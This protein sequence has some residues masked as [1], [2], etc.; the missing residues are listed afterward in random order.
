MWGKK[1]EEWDVSVDD[2]LVRKLK[3]G[4][5][6]TRREAAIKMGKSGDTRFIPILKWALKI[7]QNGEVRKEITDAIRKLQRLQRLWTLKEELDSFAI[8]LP[9][10]F[11]KPIE[12]YEEGKVEETLQ[13]YNKVVKDLE[14]IKEK[15]NLLSEIKFTLN[16]HPDIVFPKE[17]YQIIREFEKGNINADI[18]KAQALLKE[19]INKHNQAKEELDKIKSKLGS[20]RN[21]EAFKLFEQGRYEESIKGCKE[22]LQTLRLIDSDNLEELNKKYFIPIDLYSTMDEVKKGNLSRMPEIITKIQEIKNS[23][24]SI[25]VNL[26]KFS[27]ALNRWGSLPI[28]IKNSSYA[29][30]FNVEVHFPDDVE[31]RWVEPVTINGKETRTLDIPIRPKY[32]GKIPLEIAITYEDA[33]KEKYESKHR[34]WIDVADSIATAP[35]PTSQPIFPSDFTPK[36]TTPKTFPPE[37][38]DSYTEV[39]FIGKGGF[40]RVFKAK[41]K[42]GK[43]V[44]VK[45]PISLDPATGKSFIKELT[46]W[47]RL[48]HENIVKVF[49]YNILPIPFFEMEL[50]DQ[51]LA[52]L[53]KPVDPEKAAWII[54]N[55]AE[56]LK[57]AHKQGIIHR[58]LKPQNIM[59]KEGIPKISDWGLSKVVTESTSTSVTAFT[60]FYAAPEQI[61]KKFGEKNNPKVDVWQLGVILYE[62]VTGELPFRGDDPVEIMSSITM[63]T[64]ILPSEINPE[65]AELEPIIVKCLE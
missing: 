12:L 59:L 21:L 27:F 7:E 64:Y 50:C 14:K 22:I 47:T 39:E 18:L 3:H 5:A 53:P 35:T 16:Q 45:I 32:S 54:F 34:V 62:L 41:R 6:Q 56:G 15:L 49:D 30:A 31:F 42:D 48:E 55:V 40:A 43:L 9:K 58:D 26:E 33:D 1:L 24:P 11:Y 51:S 17:I 23:K 10:S 61:S 36:P 19:T 52:D 2:V 65:A 44:A 46:N 63:D 57:Y 8:K 28:T 20:I 4:A 38:S 13:E 25:D 29:H 37:L 60:P